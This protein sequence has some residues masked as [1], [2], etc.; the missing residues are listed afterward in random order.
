MLPSV[1][2]Y[3]FGG[4]CGDSYEITATAYFGVPPYDYAIS[5]DG[6]NFS[7]NTGNPFFSPLSPGTYTV[8]VTDACG[9]TAIS[10]LED[11][12]AGAL[13]E[14]MESGFAGGCGT[15][16]GYLRIVIELGVNAQVVSPP[17]KYMVKEVIGGTGNNIQYG[18]VIN[19]GVT[20]NL[21]FTISG[22]PG[23]KRYGIFISNDCDEP[24]TTK[25][26]VTNDYAI[27]GC[28]EFVTVW[29]LA[30]A[31]GPNTELTFDVATGG[32][33]NYTWETIPA[34]SSGSGTF[35]GSTVTITGLPADATI[36]LFIQPANFERININNGTDRNRL[37]LVEN[38][39]STA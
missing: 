15:A 9:Q 17:Y 31:G 21:D 2:A 35:T 25:N 13:Y 24:F 19:D 3:P 39:G 12:V 20:T 27:P 22:L 5:H 30:T 28:N 16:G 7:A 14:V 37:T 26:R 29:D 38:W 34:A 10:A 23:N 32:T 6:V 8:M 33:V 11:G 36:R 1:S 4:S 18:N